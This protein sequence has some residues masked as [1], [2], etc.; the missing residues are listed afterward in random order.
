MAS[1]AR[2]LTSALVLLWRVEAAEVTAPIEGGAVAMEFDKQEQRL[3]VDTGSQALFV[4][5]KEWYEKTYAGR[6]CTTLSS[7]CYTCPDGC[8][9]YRSSRKFFV[10]FGDDTHVT[11]VMHE[12]SIT[13]GGRVIHSATFGLIIGFNSPS[14]EEEPHGLLGLAQPQPGGPSPFLKQLYAAGVIQERRF[15]VCTP[16]QSTHLDGTLTLGG[17]GDCAVFAMRHME[18]VQ[19]R[20]SQTS[21]LLQL[22]LSSVSV[23]TGGTMFIALDNKLAVLDTGDALIRLPTQL[24]EKVTSML[25]RSGIDHEGNKWL[26]RNTEMEHMPI[27]QLNLGDFSHGACL[28][29]R[30]AYYTEEYSDTLRILAIEP[31]ESKTVHLGMPFF[32]AYYT[33]FDLE[34]STLEVAQYY[35]RWAVPHGDCSKRSGG[36]LWRELSSSLL[37]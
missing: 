26:I 30:P 35:H 27:L 10:E 24:Y 29:L 11:F 19:S 36:D 37:P 21:S 1:I 5:Y 12:G 22:R 14:S 31:T 8:D 18:L 28:V 3:I 32:R 25:D 17:R 15:S 33:H 34:N 2:A 13:I 23:A 4:V 20:A 7:G 16:E 6:S 9:P